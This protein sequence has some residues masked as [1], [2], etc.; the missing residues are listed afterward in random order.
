MGPKRFQQPSLRRGT[1]APR[2]FDLSIPEHAYLFGLLQTDGHHQASTRNRGRITIELAADD[3]VLLHRLVDIVPWY[4]SVRYRT[5][6]TNF[7]DSYRSATWTLSSWDARAELTLLGLPP[8][9][10]SSTASPP[11]AHHARRD[12]VR[13]LV[14]GDGSVGFTGSGKPFVSFVS[15]SEALIRYFEAFGEEITG[16]PRRTNRNRRD[17]VFNPMYQSDAAAAL[18]RYLYR[19]G[20]LALERKAR[21]ALAAGAWARPSGMRRSYSAKRWSAEEDREALADRPI[22][23]IAADLGRT[24]QS[25]N[26][27]RTRLRAR[28]ST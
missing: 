3:A 9:P 26:A 17:G 28:A 4:S 6:D 24:Y 1:S 16:V 18:A 8:G 25:V 19:P 7:R 14:D 13:G 11:S 20:D 10:K 23:A 2:F 12:Y 21:A 5:R 27:R 15:A 22:A